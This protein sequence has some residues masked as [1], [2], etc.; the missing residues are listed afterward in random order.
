MNGWCQARIASTTASLRRASLTAHSNAVRAASDPSTPTTILSI[1][2]SFVVA[3]QGHL[4][5]RQSAGCP[6]G[7]LDP[8]KGAVRPQSD[9]PVE[10]G[11]E[12][13]AEQVADRDDAQ[14]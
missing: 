2:L 14:D 10:A 5:R 12:Q 11:G 4:Q 8:R 13:G 3:L 9:L 6:V 1:A 7:A